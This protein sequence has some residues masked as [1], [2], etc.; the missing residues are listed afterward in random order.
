[1]NHLPAHQELQGER[2]NCSEEVI[3]S[4][5]QA[6]GPSPPEESTTEQDRLL[7][8]SWLRNRTV[9]SRGGFKE[10]D[11]LLP[12]SQ[13]RNRTVSSRGVSYETGPSPPEESATE[14]DRL[15]PRSWLRNRTVSSRGVFKE[16]DRLLPRSRQGTGPSP[17]EEL[18]TEQDNLLL[19]N[20]LQNHV[21]SS[22]E[23]AQEWQQFGVRASAHT[24][25][26]RLLDNGLVSRRAAK[27]PLLSKKNIKNRLKFCRKYKDWTDW[28]KLI[29]SEAPFQL[30]WTSGKSIVQRR[31][32]E[33]YHE[34]CVVPTVKHPE[35]IHVCACF[36][37]KGVGT[38]II[39]PKI[40]AM[41]KEWYQNILQERLPPTIHE[42]FGDD[43]CIFQHDEAPCHKA[44]V[45]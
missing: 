39:V 13:L 22:A 6:P 42:Q 37:I 44:K 21:S 4:V 10:Q 43:P 32:G 3:R 8:R 29:F 35:T 19:R 28:C 38:L 17:P 5:Q 23:L 2:F 30:F 40:T 27:K 16:Q 18:A 25:R 15:L 7:P 11:R 45:V 36:S 33:R 34:S 24:V 14:Q 31:K 12:R 26:I 1:K 41:N 20:Q 9:S